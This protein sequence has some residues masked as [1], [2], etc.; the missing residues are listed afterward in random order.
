[1]REPSNGADRRLFGR[2]ATYQ[3]AVV[4]VSGRTPV[5]CV[6]LDISAG[7]ALLDFGEAVTLP[8]RLRLVWEGS[9]DQAL[10]EVRHI[11]GTRAGVQFLCEAGP[12]IARQSITLT[13]S[14]SK[15][16]EA[17]PQRQ[18]YNEPAQSSA[19][20]DLVQR[21]RAGISPAKTTPSKT[22]PPKLAT[23]VATTGVATLSV[24]FSPRTRTR[25]MTTADLVP[26]APMPPW[27]YA[28]TATSAFEVSTVLQILQSPDGETL[29]TLAALTLMPPLQDAECATAQV[30]L[31]AVLQ[32]LQQ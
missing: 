16:L 30:E 10:C 14:S 26:P 4:H 20:I 2:R 24:D 12:R 17:A 1:M 22:T 11:Q 13:E 31:C 8:S 29:P 15:P 5:R 18:G 6:V 3:H 25:A 23:V 19:A 9:G 28:K 21:F 27:R 7:G 32:L